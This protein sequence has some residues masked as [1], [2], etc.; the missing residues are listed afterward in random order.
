LE[1]LKEVTD[2]WL[3]ADLDAPRKRRHT[4]KRIHARLVGEYGAAGVSY[5]AVRDYVARRRPEIAE[6]EGRGPPGQHA[7][8]DFGELWVRLAGVMTKCHLFVLRLS[9]SG[10]AVHRPSVAGKRNNITKRRV[11][12]AP[13]SMTSTHE[14]SSVHQ[15]APLD[16]TRN[17]AMTTT[18]KAGLLKRVPNADYACL[19]SVPAS[20]VMY[21]CDAALADA[22]RPARR[23]LEPAPPLARSPPTPPWASP[24]SPR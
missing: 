12:D 19:A 2:G 11:G 20:I 18:A 3:R 6:E 15:R 1:P 5:S 21:A 4:A 22:A 7:E 24:S 17:S 8:V 23:P 9:Y 16:F 14:E 10:K 13:R